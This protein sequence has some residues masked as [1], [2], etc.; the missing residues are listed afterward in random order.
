M[1]G[2][3]LAT[4]AF[5]EAP[6]PAPGVFPADLVDAQTVAKA[7][8]EP[9]GL[10]EL[11]FTFVVRDGEEELVRRSH[12]WRPSDSSVT[13]SLPDGEVDVWTN[14]PPNKPEDPGYAAWS[15]FVNDSYWLL[16]PCKATDA[17]V[18]AMPD[19]GTDITQ[20]LLRLQFESVGLTPG[21]RYDLEVDP[22]G[23]VTGWQYLL[24]SGRKGAFDWSPYEQVGPLSLSLI[25][26]ARE[27]GVTIAFED[28]SAR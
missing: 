27:G 20:A 3:W 26:T 7:C 16:A 19:R 21:D 15:A 6:M 9:Y 10:V 22:K 17:G 4:L 23:Q 18:R 24:Q 5:A 8:G 13:V 14:P 11:S 12:R 25:R 2:W 1:T 28:V